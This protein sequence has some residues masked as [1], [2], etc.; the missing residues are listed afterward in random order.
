MTI[1]TPLLDFCGQRG[2]SITFLSPHGHF[3]GRFY[4]PVNGN[5]LLRKKQYESIACSAFG[6][7]L[8]RDI[9]LCKIKNSK[10][11]LLRAARKNEEA[12]QL[13]TT[14][15]N[16]LS[17]LAVQLEIC[18]SIGSMRGIEGAAATAYFSQFDSMLHSPA[19]FQFG[20]RSRRPPKNEVNAVLSFVYTRLT[21][22]ICSALETV[23]LDPAAGYLHT[24]RPGRPSFALDL[25]EELRAPLCDRFTLSLLNLGQLGAKDFE[26]DSEAVFLNERGRRTVLSSWQKRKTETIQ[27]PFLREKLPIGMIPYSQAMLFGRVLRG[28]LDRYPPFVWR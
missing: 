27:H 14:A 12:A 8:V 10:I 18:T 20:T 2:I 24:L 7:Q 1:S 6:T 22:E 17:Q 28:D 16:S 3:Y 23:G 4:G 15:A 21:R 11:V 19:G 25:I 26:K 13:L 9:L 5:V